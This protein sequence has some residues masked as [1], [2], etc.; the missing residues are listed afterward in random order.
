[1]FCLV[2]FVLFACLLLKAFEGNSEESY[3]RQYL[4][5]LTFCKE[6]LEN[7]VMQHSRDK[8][9]AP[10]ER[11]H[12]ETRGAGRWRVCLVGSVL[13]ALW[14]EMPL[15]WSCQYRKVISKGYGGPCWLGELTL[16]NPPDSPA[17]VLRILSVFFPSE[18]QSESIKKFS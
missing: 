17:V 14:M 9:T 11:T 18:N 10:G 15:G 12:G 2:G 16:S 13:E 6:N 3:H 8:G 1:L 7:P 4:F 5:L